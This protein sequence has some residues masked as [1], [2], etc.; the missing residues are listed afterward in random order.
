M[1]IYSLVGVFTIILALFM[2]TGCTKTVSFNELSLTARGNTSVS[3]YCTLVFGDPNLSKIEQNTILANWNKSNTIDLRVATMA[4]CSWVPTYQVNQNGDT[5]TLKVSYP[6]DYY[7]SINS[8]YE[9]KCEYIRLYD[10]EEKEYTVVLDY[11]DQKIK[12]PLLLN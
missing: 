4:G 11:N 7:E 9:A 6:P 2:L 3:N 5:I 12:I 8:C 1:K 10:V